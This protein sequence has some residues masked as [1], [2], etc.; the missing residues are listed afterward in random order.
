MGP[1]NHSTLPKGYPVCIES[2]NEALGC[3]PE[4]SRFGGPPERSEGGEGARMAG[5]LR[6]PPAQTSRIKI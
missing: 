5:P 6:A 3:P 1:C 2:A 4:C